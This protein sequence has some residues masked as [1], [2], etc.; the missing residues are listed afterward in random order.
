M[1]ASPAISQFICVQAKLLQHRKGGNLSKTGK[2]VMAASPKKPVK[3]GKENKCNE[4]KSK[5]SEE[6]KRQS[7]SVKA[8]AQTLELPRRMTR[9]TSVKA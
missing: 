1:N 9:A 8:A 5:P 3:A 2:A 6:Q 4:T 7:S